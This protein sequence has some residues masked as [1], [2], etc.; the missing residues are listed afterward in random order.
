[1]SR[2]AQVVGLPTTSSQRG[3][4]KP[5]GDTDRDSLHQGVTPQERSQPVVVSRIPSSHKSDIKSGGDTGGGSGHK[6]ESDRFR[7]LPGLI[8][9]PWLG[10]VK[11]QEP[12]QPVVKSLTPPSQMSDT[13][14]MGNPVAS[15]GHRGDEALQEPV[16]KSPTPLPQKTD[17]KLMGNA[18]VNPGPRGGSDINCGGYAVASS[19]HQ[20]EVALQELPQPAVESHTRSSQ[21]SDI[22]ST[23][24]AGGSSGHKVTLQAQPVAVSR[25]RSSRSGMNSRHRGEE[26]L[27][28]QSQ[29]VVEPPTHTS[30][31]NDINF[32]DPTHSS[33]MTN[34]TGTLHSELQRALPEHFKFRILVVG[35]IGSGKSSLI[36]AVFK[37]DTTVRVF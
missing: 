22:K 33:N 34:P 29:P 16:V 3:D 9:P 37:V 36:K 30:Q 23:G 12:S 11:L 7:S 10:Q 24:N 31:N 28:E 20:G 26:A 1:M 8:R 14:L 5:E 6:G 18:G 15:S 27:Q 21:M 13:T 2:P 25:I 4:I 17:T 19:G 32:G 35:K